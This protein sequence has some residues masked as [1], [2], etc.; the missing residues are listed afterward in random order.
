MK[1]SSKGSY[2]EIEA[3]TFLQTKVAETS[4]FFVVSEIIYSNQRR[5]ESCEK[6]NRRCFASPVGD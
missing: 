6:T 5:R 2:F 4:T 3:F 1:Q